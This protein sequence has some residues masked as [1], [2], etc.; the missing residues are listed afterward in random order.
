[1][2]H[3][4]KSEAGIDKTGAFLNHADATTSAGIVKNYFKNFFLW[5]QVR[6]TIFVRY[7]DFVTA[8]DDYLKRLN[9]V[10]NLGIEDE[11]ILRFIS[12]MEAQKQ[13]FWNFNKGVTFRY[14]K[15]ADPA[16]VEKWQILFA[17]ELKALGY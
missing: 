9:A 14:R 1:M 2:D 7:E 16:Q 6:K 12:E 15:D 10:L 13:T 11:D 3:H 4:R 8:P 17:D 5:S